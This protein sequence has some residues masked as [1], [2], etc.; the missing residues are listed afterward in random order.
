MT[1]E[2]LTKTDLPADISA[3]PGSL[4]WAVAIKEQLL[5]SLGFV[6]GKEQHI[7]AMVGLLRKHE[8]Y[9]VLRRRDGKPFGS[10]EEFC[11][12]RP[13]F[14]LGHTPEA[15]RRH[16]AREARRRPQER[17]GEESSCQWHLGRQGHQ[18]A[19]LHAGPPRP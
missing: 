11:T 7:E 17:A 5:L 16:H 1:T 3:E 8:G 18:F 15:D 12:A 6:Q 14:G 13:P 4:P 19:V 10:Y 2:R 9:K